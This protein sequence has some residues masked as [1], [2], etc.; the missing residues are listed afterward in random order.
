[1]S[2]PTIGPAEIGEILALTGVILI[3]LDPSKIANLLDKVS[4]AWQKFKSKGR[5][6]TGH[7][8]D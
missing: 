6:D 5:A 8:L 2:F 4:G 1:M 3:L 7:K